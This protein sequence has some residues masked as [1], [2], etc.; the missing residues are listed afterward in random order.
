MQN[1]KQWA[2]RQYLKVLPK[3]PIGKAIKYTLNQWNKLMNIFINA[4]IE[5][6][7]NLIENKIRPLALGRKNYL[8]A[9][10]HKGAHRIA[11]MYSFFATCKA[12]GTNPYEWLT[13]HLRKFQL[14][15]FKTWIVSCLMPNR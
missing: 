15:I 4:D 3:S 11:M 10:S 2:E 12:N 9:G 14:V 1:L 6:D 7:S 5:L 13:E 8:F